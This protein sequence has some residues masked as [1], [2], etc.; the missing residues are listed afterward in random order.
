MDHQTFNPLDTK[1]GCFFFSLPKM[2]CF[3]RFQVRWQGGPAGFGKPSTKKQWIF[4][5]RSF[6]CLF[7]VPKMMDVFL[8]LGTKIGIFFFC[9]VLDRPTSLTPL[10]RVAE[11]FA[12]GPE[13]KRRQFCNG[14][15]LTVRIFSKER[16]PKE[17]IFHFGVCTCP[18]LAGRGSHPVGG[19]TLR[20]LAMCF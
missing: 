2:I 8:L 7:L 10:G 4:F 16:K 1:S 5:L 9:L 13:T 17:P 3:V 20:S 19:P 12:T 18:P 6:L 15:S 14:S 11:P